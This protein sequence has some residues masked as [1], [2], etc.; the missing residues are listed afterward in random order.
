MKP[1]QQALILRLWQD[2]CRVWPE[3]YGHESLQ[4]K[5][6]GYDPVFDLIPSQAYKDF[7][8]EV[9]REHPM[10]D[11]INVF[12]VVDAAL[13]QIRAPETTLTSPQTGQESRP[14][15]AAMDVGEGALVVEVEMPGLLASQTE[16]SPPQAA[17]GRD[18]N[19]KKS[20][21]A[22]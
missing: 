7:Y 20:V 11:Q 3:Q 12:E 8:V 6:E 15:E 21:V 18:P 1:Q 10:L 22:R 14:A 19:K 4:V 16:A 9:I 2:W 5:V 17:V 13:N